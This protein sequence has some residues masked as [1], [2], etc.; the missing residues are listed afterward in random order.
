[1]YRV[2]AKDK[3]TDAAGLSNAATARE[4]AVREGPFSDQTG[5]S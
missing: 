2:D 5:I 3:D 4:S 1:M